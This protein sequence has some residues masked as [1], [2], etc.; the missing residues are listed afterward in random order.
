MQEQPKIA[1]RKRKRRG[2]AYCRLTLWTLP[3]HSLSPPQ[4]PPSS[5]PPDRADQPSQQLTSSPDTASFKFHN[6][7]ANTSE[8]LHPVPSH[9]A[10]AKSDLANLG[11]GARL[12]PFNVWLAVETVNCQ[13]TEQKWKKWVGIKLGPEPESEYPSVNRPLSYPTI[14]QNHH[15]PMQPRWNPTRQRHQRPMHVGSRQFLSPESS[16]A[17]AKVT[18]PCIL[19]S[20]TPSQ[21]ATPFGRSRCKPVKGLASSLSEIW[22]LAPV[23]A[24]SPQMQ[25]FCLFIYRATHALSSSHVHSRP[26]SESLPATTKPLHPIQSC[27]L[28]LYMRDLAK[29]ACAISPTESW[30]LG[31]SIN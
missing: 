7:R 16:A 14:G 2:K 12:H 30:N 22:T 8:Q 29:I 24:I 13:R 23:E 20:A 1:A 31:R 4:T 3:E 27:L 18:I 6:K 21:V 11:S 26:S 5:K 28:I 17:T 15:Q 10:P 25:T 9:R 19:P